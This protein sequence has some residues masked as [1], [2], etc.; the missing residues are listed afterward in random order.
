MKLT[1]VLLAIL[2]FFLSAFIAVLIYNHASVDRTQPVT[3]FSRVETLNSPVR[4]GEVLH[5][6]I[7]REKVRDD[8]PVTS[9]RLAVNQ[10]GQVFTLEDGQHE[11]GP[12]DQSYYDFGYLTLPEMP[13]GEYQLRVDLTYTCPGGLMFEYTQP[14]AFFRITD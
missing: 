12:A 11:G 7:Y 14:S 8:C 13:A 5:V 10:D 3:S 9:K 4:E 6:R 2:A 1:F